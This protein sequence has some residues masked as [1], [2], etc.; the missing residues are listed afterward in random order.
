M[1]DT[2]YSPVHKKR[3]FANGQK[4]VSFDGSRMPWLDM[5]LAN[6]QQEL[7]QQQQQLHRY[8]CYC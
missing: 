8:N 5:W 1:M 3:W 2:N 4:R 7:Q 6:K